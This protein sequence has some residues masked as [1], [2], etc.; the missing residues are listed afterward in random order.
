MKRG[1]VRVNCLVQEH[2]IMYVARGCVYLKLFCS[3]WYCIMSKF[4]LRLVQKMF[5]F[6]LECIC[7]VVETFSSVRR[8]CIS[9]I[10]GDCIFMLMFTGK[11][12]QAWL[13]S[14]NTPIL[15]K[16]L[17]SSFCLVASLYFH[18]ACS[19]FAH[20]VTFSSLYRLIFRFKMHCAAIINVL[21]SNW[22]SSFQKDST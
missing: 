5:F 15:F 22:T 13:F 21:L 10:N 11:S 12:V 2:S 3:K 9:I 4:G 7:C 8:R 6:F 19:T 1:T 18:Y 20:S 16:I 17:V 14:R